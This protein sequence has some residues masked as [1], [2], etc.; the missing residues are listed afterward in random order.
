ME[1]QEV[2]IENEL[3]EGYRTVLKSYADFLKNNAPTSETPMSDVLD[4]I[5]T[6]KEFRD[7]VNSGL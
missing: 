2:S 1:E 7:L 3:R 4:F 6:A 5:V